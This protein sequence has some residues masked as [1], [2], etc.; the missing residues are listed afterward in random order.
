MS[1][2]VRLTCTEQRDGTYH[3]FDMIEDLA[4]LQPLTQG[5]HVTEV[6]LVQAE[7][8]SAAQIIYEETVK[9]QTS[10]IRMRDRI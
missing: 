3:V 7:G 6:H 5:K 10:S 8:R 2:A 4:E 9:G 1:W